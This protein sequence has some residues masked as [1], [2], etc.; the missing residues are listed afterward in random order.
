MNNLDF[1]KNL[2]KTSKTNQLKTNHEKGFLCINDYVLL[3]TG[4]YEISWVGLFGTIMEYGTRKDK[5]QYNININDFDDEE[6]KQKIPITKKEMV[7]LKK[8][9]R[10]AKHRDKIFKIK[11]RTSN[12]KHC[13]NLK[14]LRSCELNTL[15][16]SKE[17]IKNQSINF[18]CRVNELMTSGYINIFIPEKYIDK[19][20][21]LSGYMMVKSEKDFVEW[22]ISSTKINKESEIPK[23]IINQIKYWVL[24]IEKEKDEIR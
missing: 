12:A 16:L 17:K 24:Q 8:T 23:E 19:E 2:K 6:L 20:V 14:I 7:V 11:K 13:K 10:K 21:D 1:I 9:N 22:V 15:M 4:W 18:F 3:E 5:E